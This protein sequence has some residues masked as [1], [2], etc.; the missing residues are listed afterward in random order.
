LCLVGN[1]AEDDIEMLQR[2]VLFDASGATRFRGAAWR[3]KKRYP[4]I[5]QRKDAWPGPGHSEVSVFNPQ[6]LSP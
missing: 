4:A 3:D 2:R 6:G 1:H 5:P